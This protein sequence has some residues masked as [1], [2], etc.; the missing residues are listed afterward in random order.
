MFE[1]TD[2]GLGVEG[3][4]GGG[5]RSRLSRSRYGAVGE[6]FDEVFDNE[7]LTLRQSVQRLGHRTWESRPRR[8]PV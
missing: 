8:S 6:F 5:D 7:I 1:G 4:L 3:L 2:E